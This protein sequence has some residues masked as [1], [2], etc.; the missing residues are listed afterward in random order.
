MGRPC[1]V[2]VRLPPRGSAYVTV[3]CQRHTCPRLH[4]YVGWPHASAL[5]V[6]LSPGGCLMDASQLLHQAE[7]AVIP[8]LLTQ[9][10]W[11]GW[12]FTKL[13]LESRALCHARPL[14]PWFAHSQRPQRVRFP[15]PGDLQGHGHVPST[16]HT[17][18]Q[19]VGRTQPSSLDRNGDT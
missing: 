15:Q 19:C 11:K 13:D 3:C 14:G 1:L 6:P 2:P 10:R 7:A 18:V 5:P 17:P 12:M 9:G 4:L 16:I 8:V